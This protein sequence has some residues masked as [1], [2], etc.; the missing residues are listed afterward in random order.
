M[1][2]RLS[3]DIWVKVNRLNAS[4]HFLVACKKGNTIIDS[5]AATKVQF[6]YYR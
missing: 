1:R 6:M 4:Q 2:T 3:N 5:T